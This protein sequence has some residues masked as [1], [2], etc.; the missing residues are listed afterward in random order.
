MSKIQPL[1]EPDLLTQL[2]DSPSPPPSSARRVLAWAPVFL[3][4]LAL[5]GLLGLA[6]RRQ[7]QA[8]PSS[9][10]TND[11]PATVA[12]LSRPAIDFT[13]RLYDAFAGSSDFRLA[14]YRG[15]VVVIN[16]WASWCPPCREEAPVL[17]R[18][19]R[20]YQE[21]GVIFL[22]LDIWDTEQDARAYMREFDITYPNA[23]DER[24]STAVE[25]G[26]TGIPETYFITPD[27]RISRK[28]IGAIS[29]ALLEQSIAEARNTPEGGGQP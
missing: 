23:I 26:V 3:A 4:V 27:G 7:Q 28:V 29:Q 14:D 13:L 21:Q 24:G 17:E 1:H 20:A 2:N 8:G 22:G 9:L 19:W 12:V 25:Y 10:S 6:M 18:T 11:G 16:F 5:F 15:K